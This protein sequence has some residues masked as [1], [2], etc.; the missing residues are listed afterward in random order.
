M[1]QGF[2]IKPKEQPRLYTL[3]EEQTTGWYSIGKDL[4][5]QQCKEL[6]DEKLNDGVSPGRLRI[7]RTS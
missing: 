6:Y 3:E 5:Q 2:T 1:A 7:T 4:T